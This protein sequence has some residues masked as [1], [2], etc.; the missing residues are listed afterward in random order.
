M[1]RSA[2]T[3][4]CRTSGAG[5]KANV[6]TGGANTIS[7]ASRRY[8]RCRARVCIG[9]SVESVEHHVDNDAGHRHVQPDRE[10]PARNL[11]VARKVRTQSAGRSRE[12]QGENRGG[13]DDVRNQNREIDDANRALA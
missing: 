1:L 12:R 6:T 4:P 5:W 3:A 7:A 10:G 9:I 2:S 8:A 13:E 11:D